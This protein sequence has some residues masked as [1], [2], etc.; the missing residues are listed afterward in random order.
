MNFLAHLALS[1]NSPQVMTG[2][3]IADHVKGKSYL[4]YPKDISRGIIIHR[5]ID[6][7][8]DHHPLVLQ[9][10]KRLSEDYGKYSGVVMDI[11]YDH[12]LSVNWN[13][14]YAL[15]LNEFIAHSYISILTNIW[16]LPPQILSFLPHLILFNR[17]NT[18]GKISGIEYVLKKMAIRFN[19]P[20]KSETAANILIQYYSEYNMEF[21]EFF[22]EI[23][24]ELKKNKLEEKIQGFTGLSSS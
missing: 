15:P 23:T 21:V 19:M 22:G 10:K 17:L 6:D 1:G 3:F 16:Y 7:F 11:F 14:Y 8:T 4:N 2:N 5:F 18:Y 9:G 12:F 24:N 20:E 13:Q